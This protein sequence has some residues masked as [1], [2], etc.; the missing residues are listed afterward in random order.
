VSLR[1]QISFGQLFDVLLPAAVAFAIIC[2]T[3]VFAHARRRRLKPYAIIIW[4]FGTLLL[5]FT[6]LPLYLLVQLRRRAEPRALTT[7][8]TSFR[9]RHAPT[10]I[11]AAT[12][13][14]LAAL[15]FSHDYRSL[16]ARLA[17]ASNARLNGQHERA[18]REYRA[19]LQLR[20]DPHTHKLLGLELAALHQW[21]EAL[22]EYR[23]AEQG[24]EPDDALPF[25]IAIAL[26]ALGRRDEAMAEYQKYLAGSS[27]QQALPD[28]HCQ[29]VRTRLMQTPNE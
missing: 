16:D 9:S 7:Q 2:S 20:D 19:A 29:R 12:L 27:C 8:P 13:T 5:S 15:Y 22:A 3:F 21:L 11:Y 10:L 18:A 4:T 23:A 26:D 6:V 28:A 17:R 1:W 24:G 14:M 25:H